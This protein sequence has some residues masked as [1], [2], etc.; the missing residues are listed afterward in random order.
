MWHGSGASYQAE[1]EYGDAPHFMRYTNSGTARRHG[2]RRVS[3]SRQRWRITLDQL[4]MEAKITAKTFDEW[5][6][7]GILGKRL[8]ERP[9]QG[10]GRHITRDTAQR[11]VLV[12]R[13]VRAG[14]HPLAAGHIASS[15][16]VRETTPLTAELPNGVTVTIDRSDLP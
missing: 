13:L 3:E 14:I 2:G 7:Q 15:H 5:A 6:D 8:V 12:A 16:N 4:L 10:R 1:L 9:A 11:T